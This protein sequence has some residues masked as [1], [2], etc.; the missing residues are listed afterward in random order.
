MEKLYKSSERIVVLVEDLLTVSRIEQGRMMLTFETIDFKPFLED[1]LAEKDEEVRE[2]KLDLTFSA[3]ENEDFTVGIDE[4]K[5]KQVVHHILDNAIKYTPAPG[6]IRVALEVDST[7]HKVRMS[8]SD[9]GIGME[10]EQIDAIFERFNLKAKVE[11]TEEDIK[12]N[13]GNENSQKVPAKNKR[14]VKA[15]TIKSKMMEKRTPGI[16]LYIAQEIIEAHHGSIRIESAG[17][18]GGTTVVVELPSVE[19]K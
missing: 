7:M 13:M 17:T 18:D 12:E 10:K 8:I 2:A 4:K 11:D 1:A 9:T 14:E 5:F 6:S 3:E 16:G 19:G 15:E